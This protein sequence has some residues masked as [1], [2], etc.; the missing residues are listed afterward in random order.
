MSEQRPTVQYLAITRSS[1]GFC[2][3]RSRTVLRLASIALLVLLALNTFTAEPDGP[4]QAQH[5]LKLRSL[6]FAVSLS[7]APSL[8][9]AAPCPANTAD[10]P[11]LVNYALQ[12]CMTLRGV[13]TKLISHNLEAIGVPQ[14]VSSDRISAPCLYLSNNRIF[15]DQHADRH[16]L[17]PLFT[18]LKQLTAK[19]RLPDL[20]LPVSLSGATANASSSPPTNA[21]YP[22]TL[23]QTG[24]LFPDLLTNSTSST[25]RARR[26]LAS[27]ATQAVWRG[28]ASS[29][30]TWHP[31]RTELLRFGV[32]N[33]H[34]LDSG[35]ANWPERAMQQSLP[36]KRWMKLALDI[37]EQEAMYKHTIWAPGDG[38]RLA[39]QLATSALVFIVEGGERQWYS[40]LIKPFIHYIPLTVNSTH[41][42]LLEMLTWAVEHDYAAGFIPS[43]AN[44]VSD[45]YLSPSGRECYALQT[46]YRLA[47]QGFGNFAVPASAVDVSACHDLDGCTAREAC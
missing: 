26:K 47:K 13:Y 22:C 42:N 21:S 20:V 28:T 31:S 30:D 5:G 15:L 9:A 1:R 25:R 41:N 16:A 24:S 6:R 23:P 40:H 19:V 17:Q 10:K 33:P 29:I 4:P 11:S 35:V 3:G 2:T 14:N 8:A 7:K 36:D 12:N 39:Q 32:K 44:S 38:D 43:Q 27:Q 34:L 37:D 18:L 45:M 46:L